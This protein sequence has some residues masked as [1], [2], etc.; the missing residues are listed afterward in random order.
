MDNDTLHMIIFANVLAMRFHPR[1]GKPEIL[2]EIQ[3]AME[4]ADWASAEHGLRQS[5]LERV[6]AMRESELSHLSRG[7]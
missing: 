5:Q 3:Y 1:N 2:A 7:Q 6:R 4:I